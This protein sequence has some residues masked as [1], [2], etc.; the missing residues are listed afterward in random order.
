M[1]MVRG[2]MSANSFVVISCQYLRGQNGMGWSFS[3]VPD[4]V[5]PDE[6]VDHEQQEHGAEDDEGGER[7]VKPPPN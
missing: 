6:P 5:E 7:V 2:S 4:A 3:T 1:A